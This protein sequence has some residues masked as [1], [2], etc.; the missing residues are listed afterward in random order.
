MTLKDPLP[1]FKVT[2][3]FDAIT[4]TVRETD[5]QWNTYRDLQT[6]YSTVSFRMAWVT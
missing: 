3:F 2:P 4:E 5:I 1:G 6:P